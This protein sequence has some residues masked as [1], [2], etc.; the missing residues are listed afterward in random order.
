M[1]KEEL[2]ALASQGI[3]VVFCLKLACRE[4]KQLLNS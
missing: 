1:Q 2:V 4:R 3:Q